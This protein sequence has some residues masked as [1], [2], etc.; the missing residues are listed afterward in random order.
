M[1]LRHL[2]YFVAAA[3]EENF[4]R[5]AAKLN[6]AQP[7]L[8]RQIRDLE[9]ELGIALFDR[10]P[11]RVRLSAAGRALLSDIRPVLDQVA[12]AR[13]RA[14]LLARGQV[15]TLVIGMNSIAPQLPTI[16]TT[17]LTYR[18]SHPGVELK[19]V[20]MSSDDQ[21]EALRRT[22]I[23]IGC[24]YHRPHAPE[25]DHLHIQDDEYLLAVPRGHR[26]ATAR[27]IRLVDL[28]DEDLVWVPPSAGTKVHAHL[29]DA[30][31]AGGLN[32]RLSHEVGGEDG[33]ISF[34]EA[35]ICLAFVNSSLRYRKRLE[36]IVLRPVVDLKVKLRLDW[37]WR[38]ADASP[39][40]AEFL[41]V[42]RTAL[43][44]TPFSD[45]ILPIRSR[46]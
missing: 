32:P 34:V 24:M 45:K 11:R 40:I 20:T 16:L 29:I 33:Q 3:E 17:L 27:T 8:S 7:A 28:A 38:R 12:R 6:V 43:A 22:R 21:T 10:L 5:A 39:L 31:I 19:V 35:G 41:G 37:S 1:E 46:L 15:G 13:N 14:S 9:V 30:C 2:R 4:N 18:E 42:F 44:G 23:D 26:F 25:L 36:N